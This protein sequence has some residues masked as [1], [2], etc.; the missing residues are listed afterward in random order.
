MRRI[1]GELR[2]GKTESKYNSVPE[3]E[4]LIGYVAFLPGVRPF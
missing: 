2:L 3:S 4:A 1:E